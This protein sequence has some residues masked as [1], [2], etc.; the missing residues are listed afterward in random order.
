LPTSLN[1]PEVVCFGGA[2]SAGIFVAFR[3]GANALEN[4]TVEP[5]TKIR[6]VRL[7][8]KSILLSRLCFLWMEKWSPRCHLFL[9]AALFQN[10][11]TKRHSCLQSHDFSSV[12]E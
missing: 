1:D 11:A 9:D 8:G 2:V 4:G 10:G 3:R 5:Q 12:I 7:Q 6:I